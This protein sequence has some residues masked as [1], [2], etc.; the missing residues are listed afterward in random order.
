MGI[1]DELKTEVLKKQQKE[2]DHD[3]ESKAQEKFYRQHLQPLMLRAQTYLAD[4]VENLNIVVPEIYPRYP[5]DPALADGIRLRQADYVF[6]TDDEL[7]PRRL[8]LICDCTME[9]AHQFLAPTKEAVKRSAELLESRKFPHHCRNQLDERHHVIS[10]TF[11]LEGPLKAHVCILAHPEDRCVYIILQNLEELPFKRYKFVPKKVDAEL[12]DRLVRVLL[13]KESK[14]LE[15]KLS[16]DVRDE[17]RRKLELEKR[18]KA[19]ELAKALAF[20]EAETR[21]EEEAKLVNRAKRAVASAAGEVLK[22]FSKK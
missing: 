15:V 14:L 16:D 19:D 7:N 17:L 21:A 20:Q 1:L 4:V 6:R 22:V 3:G 8:D 2:L 18:H 11:I 13:R 12:L 10:A 5:L 9:Q